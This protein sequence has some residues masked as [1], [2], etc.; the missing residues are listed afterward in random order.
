MSD[1]AAWKA[2]SRVDWADPANTETALRSALL[3]LRDPGTLNGLLAAACR[4][5]RL[6]RLSEVRPWGDRLTVYDDPG[7]GVRLRLQHWLGGRTDPHARPHN[8]RW[9]FASTILRGSY[10]HH[11]YGTVDEVTDR[12]AAGPVRPL[13]VRTEA[14]GSLYVLHSDEVHAATAVPGTLSLLLRG[15]AT[16]DHAVR[17]GPDHTTLSERKRGASAESPA[18]RPETPFTTRHA[19]RLATELTAIRQAPVPPL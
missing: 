17:L 3:L 19:V 15:P 11:L 6:L 14:T 10:E 12:L 4:D 8:H 1:T 9:S 5:D 16:A 13:R 2:L 18:E 7:S